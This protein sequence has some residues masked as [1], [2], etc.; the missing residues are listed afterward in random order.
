M[1]LIAIAF[2]LIL[3]GCSAGVRTEP[4]P[5]PLVTTGEPV[6]AQADPRARR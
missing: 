5:S 2:T 1:R 6:S 3:A 4:S